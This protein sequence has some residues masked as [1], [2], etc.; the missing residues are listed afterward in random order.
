MIEEKAIIMYYTTQI[1]GLIIL[2]II[3]INSN[4]DGNENN[5]YTDGGVQLS[6]EVKSLPGWNGPLSSK[7]Y[8][9]FL[10]GDSINNNKLHY[11]F[12]EC[13]TNP[14]DAP[15][16]FWFNGGP[17]ASSLYG[18]LVELGIITIKLNFQN[19]YHYFII[20]GPYLLSDLSLSGPE[21]EATKIPQL[22]YNPYGWQKISNIVAIS[23]PPP[24]GFSYCNGNVQASG[25][26]CTPVD[27]GHWN[28][29]TT[30]L[31]TYQAVKSFFSKF[32]NYNKND[33][34]I[35][36]ESYAG[37]YVP[38]LVQNILKGNDDFPIN[39]KGFA[40]GDACTPP[41][42]CGSKT[43][44]PYYN[45]EFLFGKNAFSNSL[46][47]SIKAACTSEELKNGILSTAC[48]AEVSK[49]SAEAGGYWLYAYYDDCWYEN[50]IRRSLSS[51]LPTSPNKDFKYY[52][53]PIRKL[54]GGN[55]I[56]RVLDVPQNGYY[57]GGPNAQVMW[58][59]LPIV[60]KALNVPVDAVF[61]QCDNG[62]G[63]SYWG[64]QQD[65]VS[66]YKEI[67]T[68]NKLRILVYNGDTDP[69]INAFDSQDWVESLGFQKTEGWR[70]WTTDDC[71]RMG[72]YVIR[73]ENNF[74]FLT[75]KGSGHMVPQ[76]K[77]S[78]SLEFI[79][80]FLKGEN[81]KSY[82]P[83][84]TSPSS[85]S[86]SLELVESEIEY[87]LAKAKREWEMKEKILTEKLKSIQKRN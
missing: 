43:I 63:F 64:D 29:T 52:G 11:W 46:Y 20:L 33:V 86:S 2:I 9:G 77:A 28:D 37:V 27:S 79:S 7:H 76:F 21:Y 72:G 18:L 53:P 49:I 84:C 13:E 44:G 32:P 23:M 3:V 82:N 30:A 40:V 74:D 48:S 51:L 42:I 58:L 73:Y 59:E 35:A 68:E 75:I 4:V 12:V 57:C 81:Y 47:E 62:A 36:G 14:Q 45:I 55:S 71:Q 80:R 69:C 65:L 19:Y 70:P 87:L 25:D 8:S 17:G 83:T 24:I 6:D 5:K 66:W 10:D 60:K 67:I 15:V 1:F 78:Q 22:V 85:S 56:D 61:F 50:D 16:L 38:R 54:S 41:N 39:L 31:V 26:D 34:F